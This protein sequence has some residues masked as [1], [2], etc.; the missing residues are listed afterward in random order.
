MDKRPSLILEV[1]RTTLGCFIT[2]IQGLSESKGTNKIQ[3]HL[4]A[5]IPI[6]PKEPPHIYPP[7]N[8]KPVEQLPVKEEPL[9]V[10]V[11]AEV[12]APLVLLPSCASWFDMENVSDIE[13]K[14]LP[15]FFSGK[16]LSK[17]PQV[18][19]E[20]RNFMVR[21]YRA[22]PH[23]YLTVTACRRQLAGDVNGILR[24]HS[25]LDHWGIINFCADPQTKPHRMSM[26]RPEILD[27]KILVNTGGIRSERFTEPGTEQS[28]SVSDPQ[29][30]IL[31]G[32]VNALPSSKRPICDFCGE[33][34]G[35]VWFQSRSGI[36][37][38][39][40]VQR[41]P[42]HDPFS[43]YALSLCEKCYEKGNFPRMMSKTDFELCSLKSE[44]SNAEW[45]KEETILLLKTVKKHGNDWEKIMEELKGRG[46][47]KTKEDCI[48]RFM[49]VPANEHKDLRTAIAAAGGKGEVQ[50]PAEVQLKLIA[51]TLEQYANEEEGTNH[52]EKRDMGRG[53][54]GKVRSDDPRV[55][56]LVKREKKEIK[57][58]MNLLLLTQI[59]K[60]EAKILFFNDFDSLIQSERV[61]VKALQGQIFAEKVTVSMNRSDAVG[62]PGRHRSFDASAKDFDIKPTT[63]PK[64]SNSP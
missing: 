18:Y 21:L 48:V 42:E 52:S 20:Y 59:K 57:R 10:P 7:L 22:N 38:P 1:E 23:V 2:N 61:Q 51:K 34:C 36:V 56:R 60:L 46:W 29:S 40:E 63:P 5:A 12:K 19:K 25:F 30:L 50:S 53:E 13:R 4:P 24:V 26:S 43:I 39:T 58:L 64:P 45:T 49:A 37:S 27:T 8:P 54:G 31:A 17:T 47:E 3:I 44:T 55:K 32:T 35:L 28:F 15:E 62:Q 41:V 33:V 14:A 6:P 16:L 9:I 11:V